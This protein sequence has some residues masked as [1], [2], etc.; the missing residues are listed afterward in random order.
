MCDENNWDC[1]TNLSCTVYSSYDPIVDSL[2]E[3][4]GATFYIEHTVW[5]Y[6]YAAFFI[7]TVRGN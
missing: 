5:N 6:V 1:F 4:G 2:A 7:T 3:A